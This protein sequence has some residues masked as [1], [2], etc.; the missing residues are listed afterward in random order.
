[1][2]TQVVQ[3]YFRA[4][5]GILLVVA[6]GAQGAELIVSKSEINWLNLPRL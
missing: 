4:A 6:T 1:M 3:L 5:L 2:R